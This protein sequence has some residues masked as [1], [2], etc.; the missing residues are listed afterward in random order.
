M[1]MDRTHYEQPR[2]SGSPRSGYSELPPPPEIK[3]R[4]M[5]SDLAAIASGA[6][7]VQGE[8]VEA[9]RAFPAPP[10]DTTALI[11]HAGGRARETFLAIVNSRAVLFS[12]FIAILA[13]LGF[14]GYLIVYPT[15]FARRDSPPA[16]SGTG[17]TPR[18]DT[19]PRVPA[20]EFT[21]E[22]YFRIP[23]DEALT[24]SFSRGA[25]S[26]ARDLETFGQRLTR[27]A[28]EAHAPSRFIEIAMLRGDGTALAVSEFFSLIN[29]PVLRREFLAENF[30]PDFTAF[31]E[32]DGEH[33]YP[34]YVLRLKAGRT[35]LSLEA[36]V[37]ALEISPHLSNIFPT[38]P[39]EPAAPGFEERE[40][41][42]KRVRYEVFRSP[43]GTASEFSYAW[44]ND[45]LILSTSEAGMRDAFERVGR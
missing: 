10:G 3:V 6:G 26:S 45:Y 19:A 33:I 1:S 40:L 7:N 29:A 32:R 18:G 27:I 5:E 42:S 4:T 25:I 43:G 38:H 22:S 41:G 11:P 8:R 21:H 31:V 14:L 34:G 20:E 30:S 24:L 12:G 35:P 9:P 39:G 37:R 44:F 17:E 36:G 15:F 16:G 2:F 23:A 28:R 13:L